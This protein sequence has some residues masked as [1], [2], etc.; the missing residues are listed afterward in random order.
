MRD[1]DQS[2]KLTGTTLTVIALQID[3]Q[4][5]DNLLEQL[6]EKINQAPQF[7]HQSS[8]V[9][10]LGWLPL[11]QIYVDLSQLIHHCRKHS[12]Q[13]IAF[14]NVHES[15]EAEQLQLPI[16]QTVNKSA[17]EI[18]LSENSDL[19][20]PTH[21][22]ELIIK[23]PQQQLRTKVITRP[24]RSGQQIYAEGTD[25]I[26]LSTVSEGSEVIADGNIHIY[27]SLRGRALAG[28]QGDT[29]ARIFCQHMNAELIAIAGNFLLSD[30]FNKT[31]IN[32][33]VDISLEKEQLVINQIA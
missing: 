6:R 16:I 7:F 25:L 2:I 4:S 13:P 28:A 15:I 27:G 3:E 21:S 14:R 1:H 23:E 10:D 18:T 24:V 11:H 32:Q 31:H 19:K 8:I 9:I 12:L 20:L 30:R 22:D 17:S 5:S 33:A 29:Q 26:V